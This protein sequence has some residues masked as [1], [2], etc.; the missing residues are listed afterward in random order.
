MPKNS[1]NNFSNPK[2]DR[3][4][5]TLEDLLQA[6][7][8]IVESGD[9]K[10][11]TSRSLA[12]KSGYSLGTL[13]QRLGSI[14]DIFFWAIKKGRDAKLNAYIKAM[15]EFDPKLTAND[16]VE[17]FIDKA[18]DGINVVTPAVLRFHAQRFTRKYG[19]TSDS[20][21][22]IDVLNQPYLELCQKNE[23]NTFRLLSP[24]EVRMLFRSIS[25][26]VDKPFAFDDP[27]AGTEE[28]RRIAIDAI[29]GMLA[30]SHY[31]KT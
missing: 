5:K 24:N 16:F 30:N 20:Y 26:L 19:F 22:Y 29:T 23:T 6:A 9:T 13:S 12:S 15:T 4:K 3:S 2:Q 7:Y 11:F 25:M 27:I 28:H 14:E 8:E 17:I 21:D 10:L 31:Q 1:I 18:F